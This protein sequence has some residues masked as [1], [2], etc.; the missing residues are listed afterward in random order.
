MDDNEAFDHLQEERVRDTEPDSLA[1]FNA[2]KAMKK[3]GKTLRP[4]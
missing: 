2:S 1:F 4:V 3:R